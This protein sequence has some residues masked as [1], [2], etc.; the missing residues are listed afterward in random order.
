CAS[1]DESIDILCKQG[2]EIA[3]DY[4]IGDW[5]VEHSLLDQWHQERARLA[6]DFSL[7]V[8]GA[9]GAFIGS[10]GN[11]CARSNHADAA[12]LSEAQ[13]GFRARG[14]YPLHGNLEEFLHAR[15]GQGGGSSASNDDDLCL[16]CEEQASNFNA[17][18]LNGS[19]AFASIRDAGGIADI[20][21]RFGGEEFLQRSRHGQ[22][23]DSRIEHTDGIKTRVGRSVGVH[24]DLAQSWQ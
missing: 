1:Q 17:V 9:D 4:L 23:S 18:T 22:A 12:V 19:P 13:S 21:N 6:E 15:H 16:F 20:K 8:Q 2:F 14:N 5:I 7:P 11:R 3:I 10:A 24:G